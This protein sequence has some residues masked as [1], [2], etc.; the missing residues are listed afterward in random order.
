MSL[1]S[2]TPVIDTN[3]LYSSISSTSVNQSKSE[4]ETPNKERL[5]S[6]INK[7]STKFTIIQGIFL[8][9]VAVSGNFVAE[10]MS[11]QTQKLLSENMYVKNAVIILIVYFSLGFAS[12]EHN[13]SP[14][15]VFKQSLLIWSF[16]LMFNKMEIFFSAMVVA[17]LTMILICKDYITY[18]EKYDKKKHATTINTLSQT[19][20]YLFYGVIVTTI[21]GFGMYFKKQRSDYFSTFSYSTFLFGSPKCS[22]F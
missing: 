14:S 16:F 22:N 10:T 7:S 4:E 6:P 8:L 15:E 9:I 18:Y 5:A 1:L 12:S 19:M 3:N 21:V 13:I 2:N 20:N 17:M 11:C